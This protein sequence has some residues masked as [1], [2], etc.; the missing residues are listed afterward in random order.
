MGLQT[1]AYIME[2]V[3]KNQNFRIKLKNSRQWIWAGKP[4]DRHK[5]TPRKLTALLVDIAGVLREGY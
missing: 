4:L 1:L 5:R 3:F 2:S